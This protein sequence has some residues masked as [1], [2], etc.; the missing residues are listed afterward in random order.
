MPGKNAPFLP[1]MLTSRYANWLLRCCLSTYALSPVLFEMFWPHTDAYQN[2]YAFWGEGYFCMLFL[3]NTI[4]SVPVFYIAILL[5]DWVTKRLEAGTLE[6]T[7]LLVLLF[8]LML[9][10]Q[11]A[12]KALLYSMPFFGIFKDAAG[13][14]FVAAL[15][16]IIILWKPLT[17]KK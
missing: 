3:F 16:S 6:N 13:P 2:A 17:S 10:A 9:T 5:I 11:L 7:L 14:T 8:V 12:V 1:S 4:I 15:V